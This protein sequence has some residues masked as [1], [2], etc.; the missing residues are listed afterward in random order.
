M[1]EVQTVL[2][3]ILG[4]TLAVFLIMAVIG[5]AIAIK[6]LTNIHHITQR[7][8]ETTASFSEIAKYAGKNIGPAALSALVSV[9]TR[10][11]RSGFKRGK[12]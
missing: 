8:D 1:T 7:L 5:V 2:V 12:N 10:M 9:A 6:I 11:A 4:I 3:V